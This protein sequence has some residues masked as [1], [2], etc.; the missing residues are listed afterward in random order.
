MRAAFYDTPGPAR[1]VLRVLDVERPEPSPGQ[2]RVRVAL[3]A[4]NP[5][6]MF[7]RLNSTPQDFQRV[8]E[9]TGRIPHQDGTGT[10]DA[11]GAGVDPSRAL[12]RP[13][14]LSMGRGALQP[15]LLGKRTR[16]LGGVEGWAR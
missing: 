5:G 12:A 1:S 4:I 13:G 14:R 7:M 11:V 16:Y 10:V 6:D 3:S 2:V 15:P 8:G 9:H